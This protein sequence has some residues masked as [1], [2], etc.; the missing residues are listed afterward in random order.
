MIRI[1]KEWVNLSDGCLKICVSSREYNVFENAFPTEKRI[2]LQ[3]LTAIDMERYAR[4]M[5][6]DLEDEKQKSRLVSEIVSKS[7]GIFLWVALV[8]KVF[9][10]YIDDD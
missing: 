2:R 1:L 4:S 3:D 10:D 7:D 8:V 9:R 6:E 5:L